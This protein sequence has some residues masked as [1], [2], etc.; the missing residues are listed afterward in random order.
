MKIE[1]KKS[2]FTMPEK[3]IGLIL[4]PIIV[5]AMSVYWLRPQAPV[6]KVEELSAVVVN[7]GDVD[8]QISAFGEYVSKYER[9]VSAPVEGLVTE[10]FL[11]AGE[12]VTSD[13]VIAKLSNPD[14]EQQLF[15]E[16]GK[17]ERMH[18]EF[19]AFQ[20]QKQNEQLQF[21]GD[22]A[23]IESEIQSAQLEVN[24]N[25]QLSEQGIAAKIELDR[26][27]LVEEQLKKRFTF[28]SYRFEKQQEMHKLE[29]EQQ[30]ILLSQ[31]EKLTQLI[32]NKV[33]SL[34]VKAGINGTLQRL[35]VE[36]GQ[37]V[38]LG[39]SMA[40]IGSKNELIVELNI[41]QRMAEKVKI[42]APVS[43]RHNQSII[44]AKVQQM[45]SLVEDGFITAQVF[46]VDP[47]PPELRPAQPVNANV[48]I[49][50]KLNAL[51]VEQ[52]AGLRPVSNQT[53]YRQLRD[54]AI[55]EKAYIQFG[56]LSNGH[57]LVLSGANAGDVLV[58]DN[59]ERWDAYPQLT[60]NQKTLDY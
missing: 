49:E 10:V 1:I 51:Y 37:Q 11:R 59:L 57:L 16:K 43:L 42:G 32:A 2:K 29:L 8:I 6:L 35:D 45:G 56:E 25:R 53:L 20:F 26:A 39:Q 34:N 54:Q 17:L 28:A 36:L 21:Q 46:L 30:K 55:I 9:L 14:L 60:L 52:K 19:L 3:R 33:D 47:P 27:T 7:E 38:S 58:T 4:T 40:K 23:D 15:E 41:P 24:V 50:R 48:F 13:T 31:Q 18:S 5:V 12:D 22:L 44:R